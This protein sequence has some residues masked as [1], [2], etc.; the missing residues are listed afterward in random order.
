[1]EYGFT[2]T[3]SLPFDAAVKR[4]TE[5]K[6]TSTAGPGL[7]FLFWVFLLPGQ[8]RLSCHGRTRAGKPSQHIFN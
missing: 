2:R 3:V 4:V 8:P 6:I 1:M 5:E 7:S